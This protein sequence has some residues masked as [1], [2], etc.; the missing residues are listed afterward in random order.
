MGIL[1]PKI[2][3]LVF[4]KEEQFKIIK[5]LNFNQIE[6]QHIKTDEIKHVELKDLSSKFINPVEKK[7]LDN[8]SENEWNKAK[9]RYEII[10][11]LVFVKKTK[12]DVE[13]IANKYGYSYVTLYEW[14]KNYEQTS[15]ISSLI[16]NT[17]KRGKK[18]SRLEPKVETII[19]EVLEDL[20][21]LLR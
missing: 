11:D 21:L 7:Y 19:N 8:Y 20:Y 16:S 3:S 10:K 14:I 15:E 2:D 5:I 1:E 13:E 6:I 18:G 9:E 4:Y 12:K 17:S